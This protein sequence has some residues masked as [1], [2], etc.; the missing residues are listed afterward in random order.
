VR[1]VCALAEGTGGVTMNEV[2]DL[3]N[4]L[5]AEVQIALEALA[6]GDLGAVRA[7][8]TALSNDIAEQLDDDEDV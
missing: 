1:A 7:S 6:K 3:L 2:Q 4:A 5:F 8:L